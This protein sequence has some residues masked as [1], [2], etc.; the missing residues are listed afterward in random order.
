MT[1]IS[2][3]TLVAIAVAVA[4]SGAL[5][6]QAQMRGMRRHSPGGIIPQSAKQL[7]PERRTI[8]NPEGEAEDLR[9]AGKCDQAVPIFRRLVDSPQSNPISKYNLGLCLLDL[10]GAESDPTKAAGQR[11]EGAS[12]IVQA[13]NA[14]FG[15]AEDKAVSLY[16]DG[17]GVPADPVEAQK[18]ALIYHSNGMRFA[19]NLPDISSDIRDRL[20]STLTDAQQNEAQARA[21]RWSPKI[22]PLNR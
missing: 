9:L 6:A 18:W 13:A 8:H 14:G 3:V 15:R 5:P 4:A 2:R 21:D 17:I 10:A 7:P 16:L 19:L 11:K 22:P 20:D 1:T 12:W